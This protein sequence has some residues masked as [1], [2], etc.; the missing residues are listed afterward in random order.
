MVSF[1]M[2]TAHIV[3]TTAVELEQLMRTLLSCTAAEL[4]ERALTATPWK[5]LPMK[6][7]AM[8]SAAHR[9]MAAI[10]KAMPLYIITRL[11]P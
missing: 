11:R 10:M 4:S 5:T 7:M 9:M 8:C 6:I 1:R 2:H 3:V